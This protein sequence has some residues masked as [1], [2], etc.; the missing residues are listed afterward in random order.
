MP[1]AFFRTQRITTGSGTSYATVQTLSGSSTGTTGSPTTFTVTLNNAVPVSGGTTSISAPDATLSTSTLTWTF[2][3]PT[4]Q[5]FTVQ[6]VTD[7]TTSVSITNNMGLSNGSPLSYTTTLSP[8]PTGNIT[9]Y[10][11]SDGGDAAYSGLNF[12]GPTNTK[13]HNRLNFYW[14]RTNPLGNW[15]DSTQTQEG[16]T[17]F[18]S[19][20]AATTVG[21]TISATVTTLVQRW[22]SNGANRGFYLSGSATAWPTDY[23]GR[24]DATSA[25]RP[26]LVVV[27]TTG[28]F[29]LTAAANAWWSSSSSAGNPSKDWFRVTESQSPAIL[30]FDLSTVT[31]TVT[32]AT[33]SV[34]VKAFGGSTGQTL[35]VFEADPPTIIVPEGV[36]SPVTGIADAYSTFNAFKASG[37]PALIQ[38]DDFEAG[39][40]FDVSGAFTPAETKVFNATTGTTYARGTIAGGGPSG[41]GTGSADVKL[42]VTRGTGVGGTPDVVRPELF[43]QYSI[44]FESDFGTTQDD[45]IKIPAMGV[46]FGWW[47]SASGGYWQQTTG[48]G[49][50]PGTGLKVAGTGATNGNFEYQGHSARLVTGTLPK[51]GDDDPYYG[52]FGIELYCYHL[53]QVGPFPGGRVFPMVAVRVG[54]WYTF[55]IRIKQ[56]SIAGSQDGLGNYTT[57]NADG[58]YQ[59]WIN[60]YPVFSKTDYRWRRHAE[61][62]VQG[63]WI[64]VYHGG[65]TPALTDMH[66]RVDRVS[67]AT[68]Y[69]GPAVPLPAWVPAA[70]AVTSYTGGGSVLTNNFI[71]QIAPYYES[72]YSKRIVSD[73]SSAIVNPYAG[74]YGG[75]LYFGGGHA[76]TNDNSVI[77][78]TATDS[79]LTFKRIADPTPYYGIGTDTTSKDNNSNGDVSTLID[80]TYGD[81]IS[82]VDAQKRAAANH[83][84]GHGTVLPPSGADAYGTFFTPCT[85]GG[86]RY[87]SAN[88]GS[89]HE[90]PIA[91]LTTTASNAW[92]RASSSTFSASFSLP[93]FSAYV[94]G[95]TYIFTR[96]GGAPIWYDHAT[97][98]YVTGTGTGFTNLNTAD[99]PDNGA[100]VYIPE[101]SL[102]VMLTRK[103]SAVNVQWMDVSV[104]QP[105]LGGTATLSASLGVGS[106]G[107]IGT[108]ANQA[109]WCADTSRIIVG[110]IVVTGSIDTAAVY[111][112]QVPTTL[113]DT[114]TVTRQAFVSGTLPWPT[115]GSNWQRM[116][117]LH[118]A[119]CALVMFN[120]NDLG[121]ND[122][123]YAF[124][125]HNT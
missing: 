47:N 125:P 83:T 38:A 37:N 90:L 45:A 42:E 36:S 32:S 80:A 27:T 35:Q 109:F 99:D 51:P 87:N 123:I 96:S 111:E 56:N 49:G 53:D 41:S 40:P 89:A 57:A 106:S 28:T 60:G 114:W 78:L 124:R 108:W 29:T 76:G 26:Q 59:V 69:I 94:S 84:Y 113:T 15:L 110:K 93:A 118:T 52:W 66:Y 101:R 9:Q 6:R 119:K 85:T 24:G 16:S 63:V 64:D 92:A 98:A 81:P 73:Y 21:Q 122:T 55:D 68:S 22:M 10:L 77:A 121:T 107:T 1:N 102:L 11:T 115:G 104:A 5:N 23:Y 19:F 75:L 2:G 100:L 71:S 18:A 74:D 95:R 25:N 97:D 88:F 50:T 105:T 117:Y 14:A 112:I 39:G 61:F 13:W 17:P 54:Q 79:T 62:G 8:A 86:P 43:G 72:F 91:S 20:G 116:A 12:S 46:Q 103:S 33:L 34:V 31:G 82:A 120:A 7:G 70:G 44:Y 67:V 30:R 3:G 4:S 65:N 58:V 48:N